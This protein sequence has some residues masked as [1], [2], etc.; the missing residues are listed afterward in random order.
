[1]SR[2]SFYDQFVCHFWLTRQPLFCS[3]V[4]SIYG[5]LLMALDRYVAVVSC[6]IW[7]HTNV[8]TV[9]CCFMFSQSAYLKTN[10]P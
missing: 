7:Q 5:I 6:P 10:I 4:I 3:V 9:W 8:R 1:M 2:D